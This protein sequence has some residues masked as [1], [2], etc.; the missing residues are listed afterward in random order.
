MEFKQCMECGD[1]A[2]C[3]GCMG[4]SSVVV[5]VVVM[6]FMELNAISVALEHR[7]A[8]AIAFEFDIGIAG[9]RVV[10]RQ[11]HQLHIMAQGSS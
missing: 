10:P 6:E 8:I 4:R 2:G 11:P 7:L 3:I 1:M 5:V 9:T